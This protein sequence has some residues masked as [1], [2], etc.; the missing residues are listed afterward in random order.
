MRKHYPDIDVIASCGLSQGEADSLVETVMSEVGAD[1][2]QHE[3]RTLDSFGDQ[4]FDVVIAFTS[5]AY[6]AA[7]AYFADTDSQVLHW[8]LPDPGEGSLDVRAIMNN[9]RAMRDLIKNRLIRHFGA[10]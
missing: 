10:Q 5:S 8:P 7:K 9:Y 4:S 1:L 3:P 2:S 6:E